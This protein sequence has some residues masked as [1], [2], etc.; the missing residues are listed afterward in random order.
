MATLTKAQQS[1]ISTLVVWT[2]ISTEDF[3]AYV[4]E[5]ASARSGEFTA[6]VMEYKYKNYCVARGAIER[7]DKILGRKF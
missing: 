7:A 1:A 5:S 4:R 3:S 6:H 2:R